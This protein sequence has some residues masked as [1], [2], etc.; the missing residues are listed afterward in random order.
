MVIVILAVALLIWPRHVADDGA[1]QAE[2][3]APERE[4]P[5]VSA[6]PQEPVALRPPIMS[7]LDTSLQNSGA[8]TVG[9]VV[10]DPKTGQQL[11]GQNSDELRLPASNQKILAE[12]SVLHFLG[13]DQKL[14]TTVV[15]GQDSGT[16][17]LVAGG[18]TLLA[19]G[20]GNPHGVQGRAGIADLARQTAQNMDPSSVGSE[21]TVEVDTS[22]FSGSRVNDTWL[23]GD[24]S[25]G[26]VGPISPMAFESHAKLD[27]QGQPT[28]SYDPEAAGT[29]A[30]VFSVALGDEITRRAGHPV[31]VRVGPTVDTSANPLKPADEQDGVRELARV[32]SAT[33]KEQATVMMHE[34]DNRLAESLCRVAAVQAG[35]HGDVEGARMAMTQALETAVGYNPTERDGVILADCAGVSPD[36]R[37]SAAVLGAVL[38]FAVE[39][40]ESDYSV[41]PHTLPTAGVHGTLKDR[42]QH[43]EAASGRENVRAKT[44]TLKGVTALSGEVTTADGA[45][46]VAV[47]LLNET[48]DQQQARDSAD[49]FFAALAQD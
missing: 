27:A 37:V 1:Q 29:V 2:S 40:P 15:A 13:P 3:K 19:P 5:T 22:L 49:R 41:M 32:E 10:I 18:D 38:S 24:M 45:P 4:Q 17:V 35:H 16:V 9:A 30:D 33:V 34:S 8:Q 28:G 12:L 20:A 39:D 47:I 26:E 6:S 7:A 44:G 46:L 36:N 14:A 43:P 42:F 11:Y 25:R 21:I 48:T 23:P 31:S